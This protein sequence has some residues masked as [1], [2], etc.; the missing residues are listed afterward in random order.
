[1]ISKFVGAASDGSSTNFSFVVKMILERIMP[2]LI[3]NVFHLS[4]IREGV[5]P[6]KQKECTGWLTFRKT[7]EQC[8]FLL[9]NQ[10]QDAF[11]IL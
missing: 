8:M 4:H 2:R 5:D 1:M 11:A 3:W 9:D 10:Q 7:Q 6:R